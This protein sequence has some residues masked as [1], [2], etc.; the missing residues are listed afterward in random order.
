MCNTLR[1]PEACSIS[2]FTV[3][4]CNTYPVKSRSR[5]RGVTARAR[6]VVVHDLSD[7]LV[8]Y[9][10]ASRHVHWLYNANRISCAILPTC[11][12]HGRAGRSRRAS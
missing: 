4:K 9:S 5:A 11:M 7:R 3:H 6:E 1:C 8:P 12:L 2:S 10:E